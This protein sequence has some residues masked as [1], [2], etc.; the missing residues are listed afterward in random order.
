MEI[1]P[2]PMVLIGMEAEA[3]FELDL[4]HPH[5]VVDVLRR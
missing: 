4:T 5:E 2:S 3:A 1:T